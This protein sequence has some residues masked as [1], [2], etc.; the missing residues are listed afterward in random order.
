M[1]Y[2][3]KILR[4]LPGSK[5]DG[6]PVPTRHELFG[7]LANRFTAGYAYRLLEA[8]PDPDPVLR[9]LGRSEEVYDEIRADA[10]VNAC[11]EQR[12]AGTA[13]LEWG[14]NA[15]EHN[16]DAA[17]EIEQALKALDMPRVISECLDAVLYGFQP[18]EVLWEQR[19]GRIFPRD[20]LGKPS[21]WFLFDTGNRLRFR[22][23]GYIDG[24]ELPQRKFILVQHQANYLNP[25]GVKLLSQCFWP[26]MFKKN[27]WRWW[28]TATEKYGM[29][30][31]L[32]KVPRGTDDAEQDDL[33]K[34]LDSLIQDAIAVLPNDSQ[35]E[36]LQGSGSAG[37]QSGGCHKELID[38]CNN[39][40]ALALLGQTLTSEIGSTG[41]YAASKTHNEVRGDIAASDKRMVERALQTLVDWIYTIN[42]GQGA[43]P[44]FSMWHDV[45]VD[46]DLAERD[47]ILTETGV[48]FSKSYYLRAY[49]LED[50]DFELTDP[51]AA[52]GAEFAEASSKKP[53]RDIK[54]AFQV[55]DFQLDGAQVSEFGKALIG[56][57]TKLIKQG[58]SFEDVRDAL[59]HAYPQIDTD[60][61]EDALARAF[62]VAAVEGHLHG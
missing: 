45:D 37:A 29:P 15:E 57:I 60:S 50:E 5:K 38:Q 24:I 51:A 61:L 34:K 49:G 22:A 35:V 52:P 4:S 33:L 25:Y 13:S 1:D 20:V 62:Y 58:K 11:I 59:I 19:E 36:V 26:V 42:W 40:I 31:I 9:K 10:K 32:G 8:L 17:E 7:D 39:E 54:R 21:K 16:R 30:F 56:P 27:G 14:L 6:A 41:S 2:F 12:K 46:K 18:L 28:V 3:K 43:A 47:K 53:S 23:A 55:E 48:K 44:V